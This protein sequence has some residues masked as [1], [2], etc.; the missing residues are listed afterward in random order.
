MTTAAA[1]KKAPSNQ[2]QM[3]TPP[4]PPERVAE[5]QRAVAVAMVAGQ[6]DDE[7]IAWWLDRFTKAVAS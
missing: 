4:L 6:R 2:K 5:L 3:R 1:K 7:A